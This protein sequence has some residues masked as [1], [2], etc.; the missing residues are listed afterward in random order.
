MSTSLPPTDP[1]ETLLGS[2]SATFLEQPPLE[3]EH[4]LEDSLRQ[5]VEY[6]AVDRSTLA[7]FRPASTD[8][9]R[10]SSETNESSLSELWVTHSW[11]R[12]GLD[13]VRAQ[14]LDRAHPG[15]VQRLRQGETVG[16][17]RLD[18][19]A[20]AAQEQVRALGIKANFTLPLVVAGEVVA[21]LGVGSF[22][23]E[24]DW[25]AA[26][27]A[28][29]RLVAD[30]FA[31]VLQRRRH[32][33]EIRRLTLQLEA[34]NVY[35]RQ[36]IA[37]AHGF[38]EIIGDAPSLKGALY[39]V[40]Q[41]A[42]TRA[43]VLILGETGTGKELFA[44]AVHQHSPR[45]DRPLV[46]INC[47]ALPAS[48]IES[49]LFGHVKG[50][51]TGATSAKAGRFELADNGTLFLDEIGEMDLDLQA[52]LLRVLQE[53]EFE[54][55]GSARTRKVDVRIIA[56]TN[57]D[58][59]Q[60]MQEGRFRSDLYYRLS[61][62]P[63]ELPALRD[64]PGDIPKL[65]DFF[66]DRGN[67]SL[68]RQV[69]TVP[70]DAMDALQAHPWPGNVRELQNVVDRSLILSTATRLHFDPS[71]FQLAKP[72]ASGVDAME[73]AKPSA[74]ST[75]KM[76][77]P[78]PAEPTLK[79][80]PLRSLEDVDRDHI[81]GV[82]EAVRW[83]INGSGGAAEVLGLHPSTLRHRMHKLDIVKPWLR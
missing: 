17:A 63:I 42:P 65:V 83:K 3:V 60:A 1:F 82:L 68:G 50:A 56:A 28:R 35:L 22:H 69:Q 7:E 58:F 71:F 44:R 12:P 18:D 32:D 27:H 72:A 2:L 43:P 34:E 54:P 64:R 39:K 51:F 16:F 67:K 24:L 74:I 11:A 38:H 70:R 40:E 62:F 77:P 4:I 76:E 66:I 5:V 78:P 21:S 8:A 13:I 29:L 55:V 9:A 46:K 25:D 23:H 80:T 31:G 15:L 79:P 75:V 59:E 26:Q 53:G 41:V 33:A 14:A 37:D 73:T 52:K 57:R 81:T 47:A 48:L 30:L 10:P 6:F 20:P 36:E 49:E 45:K 61:V 19:L